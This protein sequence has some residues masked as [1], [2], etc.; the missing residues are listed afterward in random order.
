MKNA[1]AISMNLKSKMK[2]ILHA[3]ECV[4]LPCKV[5]GAK[6]PFWHK[7]QEMFDVLSQRPR[8]THIWKKWKK[9]RVS[10]NNSAMKNEEFS[11]ERVWHY[12]QF[13]WMFVKCL[14]KQKRFNGWKKT[15][16]NPPLNFLAH[17]FIHRH[18][19]AFVISLFNSNFQL[20]MTSFFLVNLFW[21]SKNS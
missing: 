20:I 9:S 21:S 1:F 5:D 6:R 3:V 18:V 19:Y 13:Q 15:C 16:N 10:A 2:K 11:R 17:S 8:Y 4:Y 7:T 12:H 14:L